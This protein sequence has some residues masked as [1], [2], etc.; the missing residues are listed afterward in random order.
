MKLETERLILRLWQENDLLSFIELS[1][2]PELNNFSTGRFENMTEEKARAFLQENSQQYIKKR[3]GRFGVFLKGQADPIGT[4]GLFEMSEVPFKGQ[5]AIGYR[6]AGGY[7]GRGFARESAAEMLRYGLKELEIKE[8]MALIDPHNS[9]SVRVAE[10][11]N[12]S[13]TGDVIYKGKLC[14]RWT[15]TL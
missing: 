1:N 13:L 9:R 15:K 4:C 3:I 11:L 10:K 14:Q 12:L 5:L 2:D 8:I 6:F 7:W